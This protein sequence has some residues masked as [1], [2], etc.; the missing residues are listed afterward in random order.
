M[1][2][3]KYIEEHNFNFDNVF[4]ETADN[5]N[6]ISRNFQTEFSNTNV[7]YRFTKFVYSPSLNAHSRVQRLHALPMDKLEVVKHSQ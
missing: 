2:L 4:D 7:S 6:V 3:T 5:N 1:D